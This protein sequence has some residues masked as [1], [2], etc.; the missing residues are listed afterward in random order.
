MGDAGSCGFLLSLPA[1]Y[2]HQS[3]S[4]C[5]LLK[6]RTLQL[7][8]QT[9]NFTTLYLYTWTQPV[10]ADGFA[11]RFWNR[12]SQE[13]LPFLLQIFLPQQTVFREIKPRREDA[14]TDRYRT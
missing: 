3:L 12:I 10:F 11:I 13:I 9:R 8:A 14:V 1:L 4:A 6:R 2:E 5:L 7:Q